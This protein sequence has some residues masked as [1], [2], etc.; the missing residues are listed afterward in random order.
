LILM[1]LEMPVLDGI[2]AAQQIRTSNKTVP[3]IAFTATTYQNMRQHLL[4]MGMT[5]FVPKPFKP[6]HL[7]QRI[8]AAIKLPV[9]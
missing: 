4:A 8:V 6:E 7:H 9:D 1:D 3:I 2:A 5:D